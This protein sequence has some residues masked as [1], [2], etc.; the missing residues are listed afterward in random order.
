MTHTIT[1]L[2][3]DAKA[4]DQVNVFLDGALAC[5][6]STLVAARLKVGQVL[7]EAEWTDLQHRAAVA[8]ALDRALRLLAQRPYST[9]ELRERL[10]AKR[11][12]PPIIDDALARLTELGYVD[13]RAFAEAWIASRDATRPRGPRM[14]RH[15]LR[16]KG[17]SEAIID[18][19]LE[20][21]DVHDSAYRAAH[22]QARRWRGLTPAGFTARLGAFLTQRGFDYQTA[23]DVIAVLIEE[24]RTTQPDYFAPSETSEE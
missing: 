19:A 1:A 14:L 12:A 21:L 22:S 11:V 10:R 24:L 20:P 15:E 23:Q 7:S 6:V 17:I 9:V 13:D 18:A 8:H 3:V 16:Q 2:E 5:Q 4:R